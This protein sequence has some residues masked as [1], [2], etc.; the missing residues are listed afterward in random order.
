MDC[1]NIAFEILPW[2]GLLILF[3]A[4]ELVLLIGMT[5]RLRAARD[6]IMDA[7]EARLLELER[8]RVG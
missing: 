8:D 5:V 3:N 7:V 4:A 1:S 6:T 2:L